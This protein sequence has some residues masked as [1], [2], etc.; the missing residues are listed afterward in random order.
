MTNENVYAAKQVVL[1]SIKIVLAMS[2]LFGVI[3]FFAR[4]GIVDLLAVDETLD[5]MLLEI[6]PYIVICNP[7]IAVGT[8]A[9]DFN[10]HLAMMGKSTMVHFLVTIV[11][12][13]PAAAVFTYYFHFNI[14]GLASAICI[15]STFYGVF[16][17]YIFLNSNWTGKQQQQSGSVTGESSSLSIAHAAGKS[18]ASN[19]ATNVAQG[20]TGEVFVDHPI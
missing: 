14:E 1:T 12:T 3:L 19:N 10:E 2:I 7:F 20:E 11:I 17:L 16:N 4:R 9:S 15:S 13:I 5:G 18:R 8:I 6:I